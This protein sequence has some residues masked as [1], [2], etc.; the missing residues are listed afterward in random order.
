ML[1]ILSRRLRRSE[2][3]IVRRDPPGL[4]SHVVRLF[5]GSHRPGLVAAIGRARCAWAPVKR[6]RGRRGG[7]ARCVRG[8]AIPLGR[9]LVARV[10]LPY[11]PHRVLG[12]VRVRGCATAIRSVRIVGATK[13][14]YRRLLLILVLLVKPVESIV[15]GSGRIK[16]GTVRAGGHLLLTVGAGRHGA[17]VIISRHALHCPVRRGRHGRISR[18]LG[19]IV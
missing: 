7:V 1:H 16:V 5:N 19:S 15:I 4:G 10:A 14:R 2:G 11:A 6:R 13:R 8:R 12:L 17:M 9:H 18:G 3:P